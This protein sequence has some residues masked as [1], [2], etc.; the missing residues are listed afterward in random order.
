MIWIAF[1]IGLGAV[2]GMIAN[3]KGRS[4]WA[5]FAYGLLCALVALPWA[6]LLRSDSAAARAA[7]IATGEFKKCPDCAELVRAEAVRC[8]H[9]GAEASSEPTRLAAVDIAAGQY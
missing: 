5:W 1:W 4:F 2:T 8:R 6:I 7:A 3:A 9:C